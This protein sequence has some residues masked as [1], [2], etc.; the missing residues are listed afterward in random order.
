M[1]PKDDESRRTPIQARHIYEELDRIFDS[2]EFRAFDRGRRFLEFAVGEV[3][4]GRQ[5]RLDVRTLAQFVCD[6]DAFYDAENDPVVHIEAGRTR[7]ALERYY[8]TA[9]QDDPIRIV[10][11]GQGYI[12]SFHQGNA[13]SAVGEAHSTE[14]GLPRATSSQGP[15]SPREKPLIDREMLLAIGVPLGL[16]AI[17]ILALVKPLELLFFPN[18]RS[19]EVPASVPDDERPR[20]VVEPFS[21]V[22]SSGSGV[23]TA[24]MVTDGIIAQLTKIKG[25]AVIVPQAGSAPSATKAPQIVMRSSIVVQDGR[26]RLHVQLIDPADGA[27]IWAGQYES[28]NQNILEVQDKIAQEVGDVLAKTWKVGANSR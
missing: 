26:L 8:L 1:T 17:I 12:P 9:G 13:A 23:G 2:V 7:R 24:R 4:S 3:L 25:I 10:I 6:R 14:G 16:V 18:Y 15:P 11:A 28:D 19:S 20:I 21:E 5:E 22:S 27:V